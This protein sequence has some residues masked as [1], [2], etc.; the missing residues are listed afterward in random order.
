[1]LGLN[2]TQES[3]LGLIVHWADT[4]GLALLDLKD[5]QATIAYLVGDEGKASLKGIGGLSAA[6]A[7]VILREI[8]T[9]QAQGADVFFGE[10]AFEVTD[11]LRTASDGRGMISALELPS[12]RA[13]GGRGCRGSCSA[14]ACSGA[15]PSRI[16]R[17]D[18]MSVRGHAVVHSGGIRMLPG[19][20]PDRIA[21]PGQRMPFGRDTGSGRGHEIRG[22]TLADAFVRTWISW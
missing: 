2:D 15:R 13:R 22:P 12:V 8:V 18:S 19:P 4:Q 3:S 1:M 9:L 11:L 16:P 17:I 14:R 7:G 10:P 6:T 21:R 20:R 5:L